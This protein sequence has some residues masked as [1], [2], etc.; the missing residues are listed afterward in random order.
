MLIAHTYWN[1]AL[2]KSKYTTFSPQG[3]PYFLSISFVVYVLDWGLECGFLKRKNIPCHERVAALK[4]LPW[5]KL[6]PIGLEQRWQLIRCNNW[7]HKLAVG[8]IQRLDP[9]SRL[10]NQSSLVKRWKPC[11]KGTRSKTLWWFHWQNCPH[12]SVRKGV[13]RS[14]IP[15][16]N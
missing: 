9:K 12:V 16:L 6:Q 14:R 1:R 11:V 3:F 8:H 7:I 5:K 4:A 10:Q 2:Q 15:L 13:S